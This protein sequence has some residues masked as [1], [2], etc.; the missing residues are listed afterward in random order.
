MVGWLVGW[1]DYLVDWFRGSVV[2]KVVG[3]LVD[4]DVG[5][6]LEH[7]HLLASRSVVLDVS[8]LVHTHLPL[9]GGRQGDVVHLGVFATVLLDVHA[10]AFADHGAEETIQTQLRAIMSFRIN[11]S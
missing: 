5:R 9:G 10:R 7:H 1:L 8:H 4:E 11:V 6:S 2:R 3:T